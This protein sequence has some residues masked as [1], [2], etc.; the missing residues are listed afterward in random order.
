MD[1][2]WYT[3]PSGNYLANP[4]AAFLVERMRQGV[5]YWG[6]YSPVATLCWH[7]HPHQEVPSR[8]GTGTETMRQQLIA[9]RHPKRGWYFE[10]DTVNSPDP[11][12]LVPLD[13]AA[14]RDSFVT[15][16]ANGEQLHFL[17]GCFVPLPTAEQI[18]TEFLDSRE[19]STVVQ[20][21]PFDSILPRLGSD[22]YRERRK[23][24][25]DRAKRSTGTH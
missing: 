10:Y 24:A 16:W 21:V 11:R 22:E 25:R 4:T 5:E 15:C 8:V 14:D 9:I 17:K 1:T 18:V 19:P 3:E 20:W 2:V 13:P 12:W 6:P 7:E 23:Q